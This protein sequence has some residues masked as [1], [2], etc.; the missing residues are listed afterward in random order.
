MP[1]AVGGEVAYFVNKGLALNKERARR[2]LNPRSPAPQ[3][4]VIILA[5]PRALDARLLS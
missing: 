3:A 4:D 1:F 5:R 2:D